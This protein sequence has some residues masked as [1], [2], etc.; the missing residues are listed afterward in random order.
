MVALAHGSD[1]IVSLGGRGDDDVVTSGLDDGAPSAVVGFDGPAQRLAVTPDGSSIAIGRTTDDGITLWRNGTAVATTIATPRAAQWLALP[2]A[3]TLFVVDGELSR[4]DLEPTPTR[5]WTVGDAD[6]VDEPYLRHAFVTVDGDIAVLRVRD[7]GSA[8]IDVHRATDGGQV[9]SVQLALALAP[10]QPEGLL[11]PAPGG[12]R[13]AWASANAGGVSLIDLDDGHTFAQ[14]SGDGASITAL[15]WIDDE[16]VLIGSNDGRVRL[17]DADGGVLGAVQAQ[18][19]AVIGIVPHATTMVSAGADGMLACHALEE[20]VDARAAVPAVRAIAGHES[21]LSLVTDDAVVQLDAEGTRRWSAERP[22]GDIAAIVDDGELV[23]VAASQRASSSGIAM[24][25]TVV[26]VE[27][28]DGNLRDRT[29]I[30]GAVR[31]LL[32]EPGGGLAIALSPNPSAPQDAR[33]LVLLPSDR[34]E[35]AYH[36]AW[37]PGLPHVLVDALAPERYLVGLADGRIVAIGPELDCPARAWK[38]HGAGVVALHRSGDE[39][40]SIGLDAEAVI[41]DARTGERRRGFSFTRHP[42]RREGPIAHSLFDR[43]RAVAISFRLPQLELFELERAELRAT[44]PLPGAALVIAAAPGADWL[45][46]ACEGGMVL[47]LAGDDARVLGA[48]E[49]GGVIRQLAYTAQRLLYAR[50]TTGQVHGLRLEPAR[51][52]L[53]G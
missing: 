34:G 32:A 3:S 23:S 14:L 49:C 50:S 15:A 1:R 12:R 17:V 2:D 48:W 47:A 7:D 19:A 40:L 46:V 5:R 37:G 8:T 30:D 39:L 41:W 26:R 35:A 43:G 20:L 4:W 24:T 6:A 11:V 21:G 44:A 22:A 53:D 10:N 25:S 51:H 29:E 52:R 28:G 16:R 18:I 13:C 9:A 33:P 42:K 27:L 36:R 31:A 38:A 45:A